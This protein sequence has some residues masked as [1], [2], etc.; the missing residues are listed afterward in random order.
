MKRIFIAP[1]ADS[2]FSFCQQKDKEPKR[3]IADC[4]SS[5]KNRSRFPK[6]QKLASLKQPAFFNGKLSR[7]F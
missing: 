6:T 3:K 4:I 1:A 7:F 5:T 2:S